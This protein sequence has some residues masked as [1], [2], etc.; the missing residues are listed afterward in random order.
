MYSGETRPVGKQCSTTMGTQSVFDYVP[1]YPYWYGMLSFAK[2]VRK[3][4]KSL[5]SR[6]VAPFKVPLKV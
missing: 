5:H 6:P 4:Q 3:N 1:T 2:Y